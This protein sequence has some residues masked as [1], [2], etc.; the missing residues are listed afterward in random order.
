MFVDVD[1]MF[2]AFGSAYLRE[3]RMDF[4]VAMSVVGVY[5]SSGDD[6]VCLLVVC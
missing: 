6:I 1:K 3:V 2:G 4:N 5:G